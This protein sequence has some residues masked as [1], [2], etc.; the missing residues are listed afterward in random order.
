MKPLP[1]EHGRRLDDVF[2]PQAAVTVGFDVKRCQWRHVV[3]IV[4]NDEPFDVVDRAQPR[5]D[6]LSP[7]QM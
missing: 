3:G 5:R 7:R 4:E 2:R 6:L 1:S